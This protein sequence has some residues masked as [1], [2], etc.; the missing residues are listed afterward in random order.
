MRRQVIWKLIPL[1]LT[2]CHEKSTD[3][4]QIPAFAEAPAYSLSEN[5]VEVE[6]WRKE[7]LDIDSLQFSRP[8]DIDNEPVV[9]FEKEPNLSIIHPRI[10][11]SSETSIGEFSLLYPESSKLNRPSGYLWRGVVKVFA[12]DGEANLD[13]WLVEFRH[14]KLSRLSYYKLRQNVYPAEVNK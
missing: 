4:Q 3:I 11:L 9:D 1:I 14:E 6:S 8:Y 2:G 5:Y 12:R 10:K 7:V 13:F